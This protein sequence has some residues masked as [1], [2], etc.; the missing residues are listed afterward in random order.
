MTASEY[1]DEFLVRLGK[2]LRRV[3]NRYDL[4]LRDVASLLG[5]T[6]SRV[7]RYE[8]GRM[9]PPLL[10]LRDFGLHFRVNFNWLLTGDADFSVPEMQKPDKAERARILQWLSSFPDYRGE[11]PFLGPTLASTDREPPTPPDT[12]QPPQ[13]GQ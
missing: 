10:W 5:G 3:R 11:E 4:T 2:R 9:P 1:A 8:R 13:D 12:E 6:A 7:S